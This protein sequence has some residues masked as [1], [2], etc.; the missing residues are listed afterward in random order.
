[1]ATIGGDLLRILA[2]T[3]LQTGGNLGV[4]YLTK[5][6][7][8]QAQERLLGTKA[9][10]EAAGV[11]TDPVKQQQILSQLT[12]R[13]GLPTV[14]EKG[15]VP[16]GE[17][18]TVGNLGTRQNLTYPS[19]TYSPALVDKLVA[20]VPAMEALKVRTVQGMTPTARE[21]A[22][23]PK[24][25][26]LEAARMN[27]LA[28]LA[29]KSQEGELNRASR[30]GIAA[31]SDE[32]KRIIAE[33][34]QELRKTMLGMQLQQHQQNMILARDKMEAGAR[35]Q[36]E[37]YWDNIQ[38]ILK[39]PVLKPEALAPAVEQ[40]N[41]ALGSAI[42]QNAELANYFTPLEIAKTPGLLWGE[43][44][45]GVKKSART[46][47]AKTT[48]APLTFPRRVKAGGEEIVVNS[49]EEYDTLQRKFSK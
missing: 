20:P 28:N 23:F 12:G 29:F 11:E 34:S 17:T 36:L 9:A 30:E 41:A 10:V 6:W 18:P 25:P 27:L 45:T 3:A 5:N 21:T 49:Q 2:H 16:T 19:D 33:G 32:T 42:K 35:G 4:N 43:K 14:T 24:E 46:A 13:L 1:M 22:L 26:T 38:S 48:T 39:E 15:F 37:K 47:P 7:A 40:Y 31:Q 44:T 8:E